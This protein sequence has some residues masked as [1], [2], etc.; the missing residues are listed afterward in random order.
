MPFQL[1]RTLAQALSLLR[2]CQPLVEV[3]GERFVNAYTAV[4]EAEH[5]AFLQVISA[6]EREHLLLNV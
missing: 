6:W 4:K 5:E 1:S 2:D 3:F